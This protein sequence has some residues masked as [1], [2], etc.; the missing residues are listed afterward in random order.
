MA[1]LQQIVDHA[2]PLKISEVW[3]AAYF[4]TFWEE[5]RNGQAMMRQ[6][7]LKQPPRRSQAPR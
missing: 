4:N 2:I 1:V 5:W 7:A 6:K 3:R